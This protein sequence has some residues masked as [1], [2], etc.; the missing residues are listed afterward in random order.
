MVVFCAVRVTAPAR[1]LSTQRTADGY[2]ATAVVINLRLL[3]YSE[4]IAPYF[5]NVPAGGT[6]CSPTC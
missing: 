1:E 4:S 3:M 5:R 2:L 6:R